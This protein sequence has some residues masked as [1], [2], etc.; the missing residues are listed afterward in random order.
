MGLVQTF[1]TT[2][3][4]PSRYRHLAAT[5]G[6]AVPW[7]GPT[8]VGQSW[9]Q[10]TP[11]TN[12]GG[13][14]QAEIWQ[15]TVGGTGTFSLQFISS[16]TSATA[17]LSTTATA[18]QFLAAL[19]TI[20]P[21]WVL[22][23]GS[24]TLTGSTYT[25]TFGGASGFGGSGDFAR[26]GGLVNFVLTGSATASLTRTQR[27]SCGAGQYDLTDGVTNTVCNAFMEYTYPTGPT[28]ALDTSP[29]GATNDTTYT[30]TAWIQGYFFGSALLA[31][32]LTDAIVASSIAAG[33][34]RYYL[35][36]TLEQSGSE[37]Y[38]NP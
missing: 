6:V 20:W 19:N 27:G 21:S 5:G 2:G 16:S 9:G 36:T 25:I 30:E 31:G 11:L 18:A 4:Q 33:S 17:Y 29:Y 12:V 34:M 10:A 37:I 32:G 35:G 1:P 3:F 22:P 26:V 24:V 8:N 23:A 38:L 7:G 15:V 13:T 28:G 14:A